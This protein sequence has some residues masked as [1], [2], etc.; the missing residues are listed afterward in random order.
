MTRHF[1]TWLVNVMLFW[2]SVA[3]SAG[4]SSVEPV[5]PLNSQLALDQFDEFMDLIEDLRSHLDRSQFDL[6]A[7]LEKLDYD[8]N[9]IVDFVKTEIYFEPYPGLLRGAQGTLM[10]RAGNALDQ[11]V[12]LTTLLKDAGYDARIARGQLTELQAENVLDNISAIRPTL[13]IGNLA[14][15]HNTFDQ[16]SRVAQFPTKDARAL[17]ASLSKPLQVQGSAA[18]QSMAIHQSRL[19]ETLTIKGIPGETST[20]IED[21]KDEVK[22]YFFVE[23]KLGVTSQWSEIHPVFKDRAPFEGNL[24][25]TAVLTN[26]IPEE[27][28]HKV[29]FSVRNLRRIGS[30][31]IEEIV[32]GGWERP[33]ANLIGIPIEFV[34]VPNT[35]L[36][37]SAFATLEEAL[38]ATAY[39]IPFLNWEV[40]ETARSFD[41]N[42]QYVDLD[43]M[44]H[45]AAGVFQEVGKKFAS[46]AG[47][48][49]GD[50]RTTDLLGLISQKLEYTFVSPTGET[51]SH[52][53]SFELFTKD[54]NLAGTAQVDD[55]TPTELAKRLFNRQ[56]F[57]VSVGRLPDSMIV[58]RV[59]EKFIRNKAVLRASVASRFDDSIDLAA[60]ASANE[61]DKDWLGLFYLY[62]SFD[63]ILS[64]FPDTAVFRDKPSLVVYTD[65]AAFDE[66]G[67]VVVDIVSNRRR[68]LSWNEN[69][70]V[71]RRD[72]NM[73]VGIWESIQEGIFL[74][75]GSQSAWTV[76]TYVEQAVGRGAKLITVTSEV[77]IDHLIGVSAATRLA[78][79]DDIERG[80]TILAP[81][82]KMDS[83]LDLY[84]WWRIDLETGETL[85]RGGDGKGMSVKEY[86]QI[87]VVAGIVAFTVCL[88]V[89]GGY[90]VGGH[91]SAGERAKVC[92]GWAIPSGGLAVASTAT[93]MGAAA[94]PAGI[95]GALS[96]LAYKVIF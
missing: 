11:A 39:F 46:A 67:K 93:A 79:M 45:S 48:L 80:Y 32:I 85:G 44:Q 36:N 13:P 63:Q 82:S 60:V 20:V 47:T 74:D 23:V 5:P 35:L 57:M 58:D 95:I 4:P 29:R 68:A 86:I 30:R 18:L 55:Y 72:V 31:E 6:N 77:D 16:L 12:L 37:S 87:L 59:L 33:A 38:A 56:I 96:A 26:A 73:A 19:T 51:E 61:I 62:S 1:I 15:I 75:G 24:T 65:T 2:N 89:Q 92:L 76:P 50:G 53:R 90:N 27:F 91:M 54:N 84:G 41:S 66:A 40:P 14:A 52:V 70:L 43:A 21:I 88:Y 94:G 8:A 25:T 83:L 78:M 34:I 64:L 22:D 28:L 69:Q 81:S 17:L 9:N 49:A 42:G 10:S 71:V 3:W 7:L